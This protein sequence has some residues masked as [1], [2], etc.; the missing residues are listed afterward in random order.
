MSESLRQSLPIGFD[1]SHGI[2]SLRPDDRPK[3]SVKSLTGL[4]AHNFFLQGTLSA[5]A[6]HCTAAR[7]FIQGNGGWFFGGHLDDNSEVV[8]D[9]YAVGFS[10]PSG[11]RAPLG[12][13]TG[14]LG[15]NLTSKPQHVNFRVGGRDEWIQR[16]YFRAIAEGVIFELHTSG[17][18]AGLLGDLADDF[19]KVAR[20]IELF[21]RLH[22]NGAP[23]PSADQ[24][25]TR[26]PDGGD[27][28]G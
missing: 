27:G 2:R 13:A 4:V 20:Q 19:K 24:G 15:S 16:N 12:V 25:P 28:S 10:V 26:P 8:G 3:I 9:N 11:P 23:E 17:D 21:F 6:V 7:V 22:S 5:G 18:L 14:E 1:P